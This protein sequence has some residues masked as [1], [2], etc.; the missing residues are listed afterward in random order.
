[1]AETHATRALEASVKTET[2]EKRTKIYVPESAPQGCSGQ[3]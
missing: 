3:F 2:Y 1:M